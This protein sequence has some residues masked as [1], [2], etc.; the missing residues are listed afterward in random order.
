MRWMIYGATGYTGTL[1]TEEALRRGHRPVLAGRS[2]QLLAPL[3]ERLGL[4]WTAVALDDADGLARAVEAVDLVFHA[5][6]PFVATSAPMIEACLRA[7]AHYVDITGELS[8]FRHT[9]AQDARARDRGVLLLSGAGFDVIPSDCL[10]AHVAGSV[11]G[12]TLIETAIAT[13]SRATAGTTRSA[14][15]MLVEGS[16]VRRGGRLVALPLGSDARRIRFADRER[17][18]VPVPWGD[19]ETVYRGTGAPDI[20]ACLAVSG[21]AVPVMRLVGPLLRGALRVPALR[22]AVLALA[23]RLA[24]GPSA[25]VRD[26]GRSHLW[27]RAV[28]GAGREAQAWLEALEPYHF[29]AVAGVRCA[30]HVLRERPTGA[31]TPAQALGADFVL[32]IAG[33]RRSSSLPGEPGGS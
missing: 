12:A 1:V 28:D 2:A 29:T 18:C 27:A 23:G 16:T 14:L 30:E 21:A 13:H 11:P 8:V 10:A 15:G 26:A 9:Y 25:E 19:L 24:R 31:L 20:T 33:T 6:G 22:R 3:A 32:E 4:E 17:V 7:G 5:A